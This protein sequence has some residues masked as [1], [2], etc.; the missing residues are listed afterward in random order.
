M[1]SDTPTRRRKSRAETQVETRQRLLEAAAT[2]FAR[3]GYAGASLG[4]LADAAGY[5]IGAVY[6]NFANKEQVFVELMAEHAADRVELFVDALRSARNQPGGS[7]HELGRLLIENADKNIDVAALQTEFW[8]HAIRNPDTMAILAEGTRKTLES[9]HD[10]LSEL[11]QDH[12][13]DQDV[14]SVETFAVVVL[15]LYQGLTRQRRTDP[16]RVSEELFGQALSWQLAG[17][18]KL[19]TS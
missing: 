19:P 2:T 9:L 13:V 18:P 1:S 6:S 16:A 12:H 8:L 15:A 17:M 14:V 4:E 10:V 11:L 7:L 5:S 3:K